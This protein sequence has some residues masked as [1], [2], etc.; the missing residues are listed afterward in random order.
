MSRGIWFRWL[1]EVQSYQ[2]TVVHRA[3]RLIPHV[4][5]LSRSGHLPPPEEEETRE[6]GEFIQSLEDNEY[7]PEFE[8]A[9]CP[10]GLIRAQR[11]DENIRQVLTWLAEGKQMTKAELKEIPDKE[12]RTY[13]HNLG[14]LVEKEGTL[15]QKYTPNRPMNRQKLRAVVPEELRDQVFYFSHVHPAAG[16]FGQKGTSTRAAERFWWPGMGAE[17]RRRVD[18]CQDC[19]AKLRKDSCKGCTAPADP[20]Q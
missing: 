15:Y 13:A 5:G 19:L 2:F 17:L 4:D 12:L 10:E 7:V 3:G 9:L 14:S 16:H 8:E 18:K 1:A 6:Q 20:E 11:H